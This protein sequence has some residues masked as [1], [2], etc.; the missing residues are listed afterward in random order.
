[1]SDDRATTTE[2]GIARE[3]PVL[4]LDRR[5]L[6]RAAAASSLA[7]GVIGASALRESVAAQGTPTAGE[8]SKPAFSTRMLVQVGELSKFI[9]VETDDSVVDFTGGDREQTRA[10]ALQLASDE[11][12][13]YRILGVSLVGVEA[14][15][16]T[17][18][19]PSGAVE[20]LSVNEELLKKL[21]PSLPGSAAQA[22]RGILVY[23]CVRYGRYIVCRLCE[24]IIIDDHV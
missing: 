2:A 23:C 16:I 14:V 19:K 15:T 13:L 5:A 17:K 8:L 10:L 24:I 3:G 4:K 11:L 18:D 22:L 6:V 20:L 12:N 21:K 1:M 7:T 9:S